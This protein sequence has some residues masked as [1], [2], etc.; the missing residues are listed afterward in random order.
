M[1]VLSLHLA[2]V[3]SPGFVFLTEKTSLIHSV[4]AS[5]FPIAGNTTIGSHVAQ[6][7]LNLTVAEDDLGTS[8]PPASISQVLGC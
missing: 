8:E 1:A 7:G 3:L 4:C 5:V 6:A 2:D